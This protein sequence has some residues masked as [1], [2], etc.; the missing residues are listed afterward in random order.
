MEFPVVEFPVA[1]FPVAEF[2]AAE[3]VP[4]GKRRGKML[5]CLNTNL[6]IIIAGVAANNY[7][8]LHDLLLNTNNG[9][10]FLGP[11]SYAGIVISVLIIAYGVWRMACP[12]AG[13]SA[14]SPGQEPPG[15]DSS[16]E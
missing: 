14:E 12:A 5:K 7:I 6:L 13:S 3:N 11:Q 16:G 15:Q 9:L 2:P 4:P 8:Y 1:E 10:I